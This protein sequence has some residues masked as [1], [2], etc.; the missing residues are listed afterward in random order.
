LLRQAAKPSDELATVLTPKGI[1]EQSSWLISSFCRG[2]LIKKLPTQSHQP[3]LMTLHRMQRYPKL[4]NYSF[5]LRI[6]WFIC[7]LLCANYLADS[8][9]CL[10]FA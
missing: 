10:I 3:V 4:A 5:N 8:L 6:L 9:F 2:L 1:S 7:I